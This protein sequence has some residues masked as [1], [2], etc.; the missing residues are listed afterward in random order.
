M[1]SVGVDFGEQASRY[2]EAIMG[3]G[4]RKHAVPFHIVLVS[5]RF[6]Y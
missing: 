2:H 1:H 4:M 6:R 5:I 3:H